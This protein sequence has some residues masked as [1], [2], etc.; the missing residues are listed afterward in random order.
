[1]TVTLSVVVCP[2]AGTFKPE[3]APLEVIVM[4]G[5]GVRVIAVIAA[6]LPLRCS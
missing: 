5:G 3:N 6:P 2:L 1:M 4:P